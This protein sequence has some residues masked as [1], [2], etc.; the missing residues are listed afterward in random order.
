MRPSFNLYAE[1]PCSG[2]TYCPAD[3]R[4]T[5]PKL[6][7]VFGKNTRQKPCG[8][9]LN[10]TAALSVRESVRSRAAVMSCPPKCR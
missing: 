2:M 1:L 5:A 3:R 6:R 7:E 9:A 8:T 4:E 10:R